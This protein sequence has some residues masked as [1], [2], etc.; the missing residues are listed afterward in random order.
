MRRIFIFAILVLALGGCS[1]SNPVA[2]ESENLQSGTLQYT[3]T[4]SKTTYASND[5]LKATL[6]V[7]NTGTTTDT[8]T[9]GDG[10]FQWFLQNAKGQTIMSGGLISD[11]VI[12]LVPIK[13]G[14][15]K[16]IDTINK[17]ILDSSGKTL[18]LG[19]YTLK[20]TLH[21]SISF[22]LNLMIE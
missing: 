20:A 19:I 6:I 3:L 5:T 1:K 4:T 11:N 14:E 17:I 9:V 22:S 10:T 21:P 16:E 13:P 8:I 12:A 2:P 7:H 15:S 18:S